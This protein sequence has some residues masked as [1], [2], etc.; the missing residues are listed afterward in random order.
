MLGFI[1]NVTNSLHFIISIKN[2]QKQTAVYNSY[3]LVLHLFLCDS[4]PVYAKVI[5]NTVFSC[6]TRL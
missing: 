3:S 5:A 2:E 4:L 1:D 6:T